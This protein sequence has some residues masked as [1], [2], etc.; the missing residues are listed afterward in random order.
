MWIRGHLLS[1]DE[2]TMVAPEDRK[3]GTCGSV[4]SGNSTHACY[5][6]PSA[7]HIWVQCTSEQEQ[8]CNVASPLTFTLL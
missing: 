6:E 4:Q 5:T 7:D 3:P 1:K 2:G 8:S